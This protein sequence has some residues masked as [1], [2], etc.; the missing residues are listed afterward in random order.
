MMNIS[1][2]CPNIA[3]DRFIFGLILKIEGLKYNVDVYLFPRMKYNSVIY[4]DTRYA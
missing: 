3:E 4:Y 2:L 1:T